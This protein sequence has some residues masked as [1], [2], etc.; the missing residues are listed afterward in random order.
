MKAAPND[1]DSTNAV[2]QFM[3][4]K[5]QTSASQDILLDAIT[6]IARSHSRKIGKEVT[7]YADD[8]NEQTE[9]LKCS[10]PKKASQRRR[11]SILS[12]EI[13]GRSKWLTQKHLESAPCRLLGCLKRWLGEKSLAHHPV[14]CRGNVRL[15]HGCSPS[16]SRNMEWDVPAAVLYCNYWLPG[17]AAPFPCFGRL[18]A[19]QRHNARWFARCDD[20]PPDWRPLFQRCLQDNP[21]AQK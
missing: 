16:T 7:G 14:A 2:V 4:R 11:D 19:R 15:L 17:H 3:R 8:P 10:V 18:P 6:N 9:F 1:A 20:S 21:E 13:L 12:G 5:D